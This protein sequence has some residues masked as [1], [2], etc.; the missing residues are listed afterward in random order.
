MAVM[1]TLPSVL[2]VKS[3]NGLHHEHHNMV[4][5][6]LHAKTPCCEVHRYS[7]KPRTTLHLRP[8][9]CSDMQ[10]LIL[11]RAILQCTKCRMQQSS[12]SV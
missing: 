6:T 1:W 8:S 11:I 5:Y 9:A 12:C 4:M 10:T 7:H 2:T 3:V